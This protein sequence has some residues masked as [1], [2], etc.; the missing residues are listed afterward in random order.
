ASAKLVGLNYQVT[1][2]DQ[3]VVLHAAELA[4][5]DADK[6]PFSAILDLMANNEIK[7]A[8]ALSIAAFVISGLY[9]NALLLQTRQ[10]TLIRILERVAS[11]REGLS[12]VGTLR[13]LLPRIF[14]V[15]VLASDEVCAV[16]GAWLAQASTRPFD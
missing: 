9:S 5:W 13:S 3:P 2:F 1:A 11:R 15:N 8:S 10:N 7:L 6:W 16:L 14:G 4:G 12:A